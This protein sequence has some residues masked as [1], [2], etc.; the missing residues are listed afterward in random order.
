M[1]IRSDRRLPDEVVAELASH[2]E[3]LYDE[4]RLQGFAEAEAVERVLSSERDWRELS[5]AI[6]RTRHAW[7]TVNQRTQQLWF[8]ALTTLLTANLLPMVFARA[9]RARFPTAGPLALYLPWFATQPFIGALGAHLSRRAGGLRSARLVAGLFPSIVIAAVGLLLIPA[10]IFLER[11][12][13]AMTH[14]VLLVL[15]GLA[16]LGPVGVALFCGALP[17]LELGSFGANSVK[18]GMSQR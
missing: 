15:N 12:M 4:L 9:S 1:N 18:P 3:D 7:S 16:W 11:N 6:H 14:P 10:S 2:L 8:P 17:F 13:W 5:F